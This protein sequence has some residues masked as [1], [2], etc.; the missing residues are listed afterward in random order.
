MALDLLSSDTPF[1]DSES[2]Q[3]IFSEMSALRENMLE[4]QNEN[5][6]LKSE[7]ELLR[8][9]LMLHSSTDRTEICNDYDLIRKSYQSQID[10]LLASTHTAE[11]KATYFHR[12][13][14]I[15]CRR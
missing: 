3:M 14:S 2:D 6:C 9:K 10:N 15:A 12:E 8:T 1:L 13:V 5:V 4:I 7:N 11:S